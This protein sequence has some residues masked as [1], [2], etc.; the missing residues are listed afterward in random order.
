[1]PCRADYLVLREECER[2][3]LIEK[4]ERNPPSSMSRSSN[5]V[6]TDVDVVQYPSGQIGVIIQY[7]SSQ[8]TTHNSQLL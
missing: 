1:M 6:A 5:V 3:S 2:L 4:A 8:L 7:H